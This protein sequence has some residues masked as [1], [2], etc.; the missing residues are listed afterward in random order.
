MEIV[1]QDIVAVGGETTVTFTLNG[2]ENINGVIFEFAAGS[3]GAF[4][5]DTTNTSTP[6]IQSQATTGSLI[7]AGPAVIFSVFGAIDGSLATRRWWG[8]EP[9]GKV[10][11]NTYSSG[12]G[13]QFSWGQVGVSDIASAGT[14]TPRSARWPGGNYQAA[15]WAYADSSGIPTYS[16]IYP[17]AI[18]AENSLPG[19]SHNTWF[20][21]DAHA[22]IAGYTDK[23][24]YNPGETVNFKVNSNNIGFDVEIN[25]IGY[26]G[27]VLFGKG[28]T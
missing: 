21:G 18:A 26:Y 7:T 9:L 16:N 6:D 28:E 2:P 15:A 17:N 19:S 3:L 5:A 8:L 14:Y 13:T 1:C 10:V 23:I 4:I 12:L 20:R 27:Y 11:S 25:R 24:S 22:Q